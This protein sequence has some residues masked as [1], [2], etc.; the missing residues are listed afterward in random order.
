MP[1]ETVGVEVVGA[2]TAG[3]T[4]LLGKLATARRQ[5]SDWGVHAS[6]RFDRADAKWVAAFREYVKLG[7]FLSGTEAAGR[8]PAQFKAGLRGVRGTWA[9][10][11]LTGPAAGECWFAWDTRAAD[12]EHA[13]AHKLTD[14]TW[15]RS[16]EYGGRPAAKVHGLVVRLRRHGGRRRR[17]RIIYVIVHM[18]LDNTPQRARVWVDVC[19]GLVELVRQLRREFPDAAIVLVGD[20][21]KNLRQTAERAMVH[22]HLLDPL[23]MVTSWH[24]GL[25]RDGGTLAGSSAVIDYAIAA[26]ELLGRCRRLH[27]S[28]AS[29][30]IAIRYRLRGWLSRLL[31]A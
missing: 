9:S 4:T 22:R 3:P 31:A 17:R 25:P 6:G 19:R 18:P 8:D 10:V 26:A 30:H 12:L 14:L 2:E 29:D 15:T 28:S 21:N 23:G 7:I 24:L 16:E 13:E 1:V 20:W 5:L 27:P 11:H